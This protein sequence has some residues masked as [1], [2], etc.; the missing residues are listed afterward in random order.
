MARPSTGLPT[1][2]PILKYLDGLVPVLVAKGAAECISHPG[3][4]LRSI[5]TPQSESQTLFQGLEFEE[6][7]ELSDFGQDN[8]RWWLPN[9]PK[10][11]VARRRLSSRVSLGSNSSCAR[12]S[13]KAH[14]C[15]LK[16]EGLLMPTRA[17]E[18]ESS[19]SFPSRPQTCF[20]KQQTTSCSWNQVKE[21]RLE[22][23][24]RAASEKAAA[25]ALFAAHRR[26][27]HLAAKEAGRSQAVRC[28]N[29]EERANNICQLEW[30]F[31][32]PQKRRAFDHSSKM[33][34]HPTPVEGLTDLLEEI[35]GGVG[36]SG[37]SLLPKEAQKAVVAK[38]AANFLE[39]ARLERLCA[40]T[41]F[42]LE[43]K[44]R[45]LRLTKQAHKKHKQPH[46]QGQ[47]KL[48][49]GKKEESVVEE[50]EKE[51]EQW[52]SIRLHGSQ[53]VQAGKAV[54]ESAQQPTAGW[55]R[56]KQALHWH[57]DLK[58]GTNLEPRM[59]AL[60]RTAFSR[61]DIKKTGAV[62]QATLL[63]CL[64]EVG[65][66]P[67][68]EEER[69]IVRVSM[70]KLE[71]LE[72]TLEDFT[73]VASL[74]QKRLGE[75]RRPK[76]VSIFQ[77]ASTANQQAVPIKDLL[78]ALRAR[79]LFF[80][81]DLTAEAL[82]TLAEQT[83]RSAK[84]FR[85]KT[86]AL[87]VDGFVQLATI[88][89]ELVDRESIR[90]FRELSLQ[91]G[92][93]DE[94]QERWRCDLVAVHEVFHKY[95]KA[96]HGTSKDA[97][98]LRQVINVL[99]ECGFMPKSAQRQAALRAHIAQVESPGGLLSFKD[100]LAVLLP[101]RDADRERIRKVL[102]SRGK[103]VV[104]TNEVLDVLLM[105]N[106]APQAFLRQPLATDLLH[107]SDSRGS[108]FFSRDEIVLLSQKVSLTARVIQAEKERQFFLSTGWTERHYLE[109]RT[110]FQVFDEDFNEYLDHKELLKV[111]LML[112]GRAINEGI[113]HLESVLADLGI[114][115]SREV[116]VN[117]FTFVQILKAIDDSETRHHI[118]AFV[119][120][121]RETV[122]RLLDS[123]RNREPEHEGC[124]ARET[125]A[126]IL[127]KVM[128]DHVAMPKIREIMGHILGS[129]S[130]PV[131]FPQFLLV[132]RSLKMFADGDFDHCLRQVQILLDKPLE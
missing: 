56:L 60:L 31:Q 45:M 13:R 2:R 50:A 43:A 68:S 105:H 80:D 113:L 78:E 90:K 116:K 72:C 101:I 5:R 98:A 103:H 69:A 97:L 29:N 55:Q 30:S 39:D 83:G 109:L 47:P 76:A 11:R 128:R 93:A 122:D 7:Q 27:M 127:A 44:D 51:E 102:D 87:D 57:E 85:S 16:K 120:L 26:E 36:V 63:N 65:L 86:A 100:F 8:S 108:G 75:L 54:R 35:G 49:K 32:D 42:K 88:L 121:S 58:A 77:E 28:R 117:F 118:T 111:V 124:V 59:L 112:K 89:Q 126:K 96:S 94:E 62:D 24:S 119:G 46:D 17:S 129:N 37:A 81:E 123:F 73:K 48:T 64:V 61:Y 92:L 66:K 23:A 41:R 115:T 82:T 132:V 114:D 106:L 74:V 6:D 25:D 131:R 52:G 125:V 15:D 84:I 130:L 70:M 71:K 14:P 12:R 1:G 95:D 10:P 18:Q 9:V 40:Q 20:T 79:G 4:P 22:A 21:S 33:G 34:R 104:P 107:E 91:L 53:E 67:R 19:P 99:R 38:M 110:V 3:A